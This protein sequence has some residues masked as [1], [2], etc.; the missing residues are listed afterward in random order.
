MKLR[1]NRI[2]E[3]E[4]VNATRAFFEA[5][6]CIFQEIDTGNDYGKDAYVDLTDAENITG[7]C[8]A[9]QIKG[10]DK[11]RRADG[12]A[13]PVDEHTELWRT[14]SV[15]IAGIVYDPSD[16]QLRWCNITEYLHANSSNEVKLVPVEKHKT[17]SPEIL[18]REFTQSF[19]NVSKRF[20]DDPL[21]QLCSPSQETQIA[22]LYDCFALG[23][24]DARVFIALRYF[25]R[26][27]SDDSLRLAIR[28]L[29][30]LTPHPDILWHSQNWIGQDI[31]DQ[32]RPYLNWTIDEIMWL[33]SE[34]P[35]DQ[36]DRGALG[37]DL[38]MLFL[39]DHSIR[40]KMQR[41]AVS[42]LND[43]LDDLALSAMILTVYWA[44]DNG[45]EKYSELVTA[46][47][48]FRQLDLASEL[49]LQLKEF[50]SIDIF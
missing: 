36:W 30:H 16:G 1:R 41:A 44:Q 4:A 24:N 45:L 35:W 11:Y 33:L 42:A 19:Q 23:R 9:L 50:G 38:Y 32:V 20:I 21:L 27:L 12:Y 26:V 6:G 40:E 17:L 13:I 22:S 31:K 8:I 49:E 48:R 34:V 28:I 25:L 2:I 18:H 29:S 14:S 46:N 47:S 7:L 43:G 3:R 37:E 39:E 15:P 10:G 5:C